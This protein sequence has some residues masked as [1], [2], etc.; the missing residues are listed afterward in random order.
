MGLKGTGSR[1]KLQAEG[2]SQEEGDAL[3]LGSSGLG[4]LPLSSR[5]HVTSSLQLPLTAIASVGAGSQVPLASFKALEGCVHFLPCTE[6]RSGCK[7]AQ[8]RGGKVIRLLGDEE[9]RSSP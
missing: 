2:R 7:G 3:L 1:R 9:G 6:I 8:G 5:Q 4:R